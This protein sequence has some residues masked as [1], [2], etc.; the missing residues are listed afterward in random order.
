M[1]TVVWPAREKLVAECRGVLGI[2]PSTHSSPDVHCSCGINAY[3]ESRWAEAEAARTNLESC[4]RAPLG[5]W[6]RVSIWGSMIEHEYGWRAEFA[7]P[8]EVFV[9]SELPVP[10]HAGPWARLDRRLEHDPD[11][12]AEMI[13]NRYAV[14]VA[15]L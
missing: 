15:V 10:K 5:V 4:P 14:D 1:E 7:Y 6:G 12:Y 11:R 2:T 9:P 3:K 13:R 8:Y